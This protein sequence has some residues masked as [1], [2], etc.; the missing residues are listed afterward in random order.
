MEKYLLPFRDMWYKPRCRFHV[1]IGF[2]FNKFRWN[3]VV[4]ERWIHCLYGTS[5][6]TTKINGECKKILDW[7]TINCDS[8]VVDCYGLKWVHMRTFNVHAVYTQIPKFI[9]INEELE[10]K[11]SLCALSTSG[12][13]RCFFS[14]RRSKCMQYPSIP[15]LA[16]SF[17]EV[18]LG[19]AVLHHSGCYFKCIP[20]RQC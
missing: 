7:E 12:T 10:M 16:I 6:R 18:K 14:F 11:C 9:T 2:L 3:I 13:K 4:G 19:R 5:A 20:F 15:S 17:P 8:T 1:G